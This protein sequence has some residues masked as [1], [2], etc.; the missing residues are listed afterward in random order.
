MR[1]L[2]SQ[3]RKD[4]SLTAACAVLATVA[5]SGC[6]G[7]L[8]TMDEIGNPTATDE[9][10]ANA[11]T[12]LV[13][14]AR[15]GPGTYD[16]TDSRLSYGGAW[17]LLKDVRLAAWRTIHSTS[18]RGDQV[19]VDFTGSRIG[20][21]YSM[22]YNRGGATVFI[23][24]IPQDSF[25]AY[26]PEIRRG[27][28]RVYDLEQGQHSLVV[29]NNGGGI[30]DVDAFAV[31]I[32]CGELGEYDDAHPQWRYEGAWQRHGDGITVS[33]DVGSFARITFRSTGDTVV[34]RYRATAAPATAVITMDG[35]DYGT[36][37]FQDPLNAGQDA[38]AF[39]PLPPD[40]ECHTLHIQVV[41]GTINV[42]GLSVP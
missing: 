31:D 8:E 39:L 30:I 19:S 13:A 2:S 40:F 42:D 6:S 18:R 36:L 5:W 22:A 26:A 37:E 25:D 15:L 32:S 29:K 1:Q 16:D 21:M 7:P 17:S 11:A 20:Y 3:I 28:V 4:H 38:I 34:S 9:P 10:L 33:N 14:G 12:P 27:V 35:I 24:G 23:D 41:S